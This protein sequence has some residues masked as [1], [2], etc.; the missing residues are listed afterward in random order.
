M[1][2]DKF[3]VVLQQMV[4]A[5]DMEQWIPDANKIIEVVENRKGHYVY[6][7]KNTLFSKS[8]KKIFRK[9]GTCCYPL[10]RMCQ[11]RYGYR[12]P[13]ICFKHPLLGDDKIE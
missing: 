6:Y 5:Y 3:R 1:K 2:G 13:V 4:Y 7:P 11:D 8:E 12:P 9:D 10:K